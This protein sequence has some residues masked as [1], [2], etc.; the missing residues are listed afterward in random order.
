[1][2]DYLLS[3][4]THKF[5]KF[6]LDKFFNSR[7]RY[8]WIFYFLRRWF[9]ERNQ[10]LDETLDEVCTIA[11]GKGFSFIRPEIRMISRGI[12]VVYKERNTRLQVGRLRGCAFGDQLILVFASCMD[13]YSDM[14]LAVLVAHEFGH[15]IDWQ[16]NRCGHPLFESIYYL[17]LE[18]F[19]DAVA[20]YLYSKLVLISVSKN[21]G[22]PVNEPVILRLNLN[23]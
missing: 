3:G 21:V 11:I 9:S 15:I 13:E 7:S 2:G 16:T 6:C 10:K 20:A 17:D 8:R 1:M 19:A 5:R 22:F 14:E 12:G 4:T 23:V 18:T